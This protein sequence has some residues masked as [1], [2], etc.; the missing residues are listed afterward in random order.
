MTPL[1]DHTQ[2]ESLFPSIVP[3]G[4]VFALAEL[5]VPGQTLHI[6]EFLEPLLNFLCHVIQFLVFIGYIV[7]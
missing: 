3:H 5:A 4:W 2:G 7:C 6:A 1:L